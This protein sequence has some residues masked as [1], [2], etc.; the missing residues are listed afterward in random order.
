MENEIEQLRAALAFAA[1]VIKSG[2]PWSPTCEQIIG[3]ALKPKHL[4]LEAETYKVN[5][6]G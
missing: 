1:S 4:V 6:R 2:E 3:A 5:S